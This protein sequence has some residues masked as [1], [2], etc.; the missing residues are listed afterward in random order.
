V[1]LDIT[2]LGHLAYEDGLY[3]RPQHLMAQFVNRGHRVRYFG[4]VGRRRLAQLRAEGRATGEIAP[5][6]GDGPA[7]QGE[8]AHF[9][10]HPSVERLRVLRQWLCAQMVR[11]VLPHRSGKT[12]DGR[13]IPVTMI[14]HPELLDLA[15]QSGLVRKTSTGAAGAMPGTVVHY[16]IMDRF[17]AFG[18]GSERTLRLERELIGSVADVVTAGGRSLQ[19]A[20]DRVRR[21]LR[22]DGPEVACLPS[23]VD[24]EHFRRA[25]SPDCAVDPALS[26]LSGPVAGYFGAIDERMDWDLVRRLCAAMPGGHVVLTGPVLGTIPEDLPENLILTGSRPYALLPSVLKR[27]DVALIPFVRSE[28]TDHISP[29]KAPEYLAGGCPV[30]SVAI[31][32]VQQDWAGAISVG[33]DPS[34]FVEKVLQVLAKPPNRVEVSGLADRWPT[35]SS[36]AMEMERRITAVAGVLG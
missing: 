33:H 2:C 34:D 21:E 3:Q 27:F 8:F 36:L 35:W 16:D 6:T 22:P 11:A 9:D 23:A 30:V 19:L 15:R 24:R 13:L 31:P 25:L 10:F 12:H 29:T 32:D 26:S 20:A 18:K 28:L 5:G 14:T 1:R 4:F 7:G 17:S